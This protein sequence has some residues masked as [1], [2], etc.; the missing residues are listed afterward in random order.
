MSIG[1][2]FVVT[3]D[4][5]RLP[6]DVESLLVS[7]YVDD[8][9]HRPDLFVLRFRDPERIVLAK[10]GVQMGAVVTLSAIGPDGA[11]PPQSL[12]TGE[13][14]ALEVEFDAGGTFTVIRGYDAIH[15]LHRGRRTAAYT[16][17][18]AADVARKVAGRAGLAVGTI[19][20]TSTVFDHLSQGGQ[21]DLEFLAGLA[22][23][24]G[25]EATVVDGKFNFR[26]P[27]AAA[28]A[29]LGGRGHGREPARAQP[30]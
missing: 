30:G 21:T 22:R 14:T 23:E 12:M 29:P 5:S 6:A 11:A 28:E 19:E 26:K 1:S 18:T 2:V 9:L 13:V 7:A 24:I 17:S 8:R 10:I 25:Y 3:I 20:A 27:Q 4:G 15:R 16:Q